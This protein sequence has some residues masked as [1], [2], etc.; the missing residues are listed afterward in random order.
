MDQPS[1]GHRQRGIWIS[2]KEKPGNCCILGGLLLPPRDCALHGDKGSC[3]HA[4]YSFSPGGITWWQV[5]SPGGED[6]A[7]S[8]VPHPSRCTETTWTAVVRWAFNLFGKVQTRTGGLKKFLKAGFKAAVQ[9]QTK[10]TSGGAQ[11]ERTSWL[12]ES[13][14]A[15]Q[16]FYQ[17]N[18]PSQ[19][20]TISSSQ[21]SPPI[22]QF[23]STLEPI[24]RCL[25]P[26]CSS[27]EQ[28]H[29]CKPWS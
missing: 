24:P 11:R 3:K 29:K 12:E 4:Q 28:T 16:S 27:T 19:T 18:F 2:K 14:L 17:N 8:V 25:R 5:V 20:P 26:A 1:R 15:K 13:H 7:A 10:L 21:P 9:F 6:T 23:Y 22:P